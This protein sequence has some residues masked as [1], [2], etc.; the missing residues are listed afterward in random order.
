MKETETIATYSE[1]KTTNELLE[2]V[3]KKSERLGYAQ[4]LID[5][6]DLADT[7]LNI[8]EKNK[9]SPIIEKLKEKLKKASE[10]NKHVVT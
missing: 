10:K 9:I 6:I 1:N 7:L 8:R 4:A 2:N 5:F 3:C